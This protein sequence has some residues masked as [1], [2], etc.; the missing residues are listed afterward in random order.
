MPCH[1]GATVIHYL[2]FSGFLPFTYSVEAEA[3]ISFEIWVLQL[4]EH[5]LLHEISR[6]FR[7][8]LE[9]QLG[10]IFT[11]SLMILIRCLTALL[12]FL[13]CKH[14]NIITVLGFGF[15]CMM[16]SFPRALPNQFFQ[17]IAVRDAV[18][19]S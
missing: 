5:R 7:G 1:Y 3:E 15:V 18:S 16:R 11:E 10:S 8:D 13:V 17:M 4:H 14:S 19:G 12:L 6:H 9:H 2:G